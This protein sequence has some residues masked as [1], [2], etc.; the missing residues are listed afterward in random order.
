M[1]YVTEER[2]TENEWN[3][4]QVAKGRH[5]LVPQEFVPIDDNG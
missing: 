3:Q 2:A 1:K 4:S 5:L